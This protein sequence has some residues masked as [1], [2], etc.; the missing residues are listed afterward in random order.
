[1]ALIVC[2][3]CGKSFSDKA[4]QCPECGCPTEYSKSNITSENVS[5]RTKI[6][7]ENC[8]QS[9]NKKSLDDIIARSKM[10]NNNVEDRRQTFMI[11]DWNFSYGDSEK[12]FSFLYNTFHD[13]IDEILENYEKTF[14]LEVRAVSMVDIMMLEKALKE[15]DKSHGEVD[16]APFANR[17]IYK[18][19]DYRYEKNI[20]ERPADGVK[21]ELEE[22]FTNA[23]QKI[24]KTLHQEQTIAP[25]ID[26][27]NQFLLLY[28][29][30]DYENLCENTSIVDM[31]G[32][33]QFQYKKMKLI[34]LIQDKYQLDGYYGAEDPFEKYI[35]FFSD[36]SDDVVKRA[37]DEMKWRKKYLENLD[38]Y[39]L[40]EELAVDVERIILFLIQSMDEKCQFGINPYYY[41]WSSYKDIKTKLSL[42]NT[43]GNE[44]EKKSVLKECFLKF[45]FNIDV[46][47]CLLDVYGDQ[48]GEMSRLLTEFNVNVDA[49]KKA[50]FER[51]VDRIYAKINWKNVDSIMEA[52]K[53]VNDKRE[54][55]LYKGKMSDQYNKIYSEYTEYTRWKELL[56][57]KAALGL[58]EICDLFESKAGISNDAASE[59]LKK[60]LNIS[61]DVFIYF[62]HDDSVFKNG[63]NGFAITNQGFFVREMFK[64]PVFYS[65]DSL[66]SAE[67]TYTV[68]SGN[69][70]VDD[71]TLF[72]ITGDRVISNKL[73]IAAKYVIPLIAPCDKT[74]DKQKV[75]CVFCGR[76]IDIS[77]KFCQF[78]GEKNTSG[79]N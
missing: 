12:L 38:K 53:E 11:G 71:K 39:K 28:L 64:K 70:L 35:D 5:V 49:L 77:S 30:D 10:Y 2:V 56:E 16:P 76:K 57:E 14:S 31:D 17:F 32:Y 48:N 47:P 45:P 42:I 41:N 4:R 66:I 60:G 43:I 29:N 18:I 74:E 79:M 62:A 22:A 20:E 54:F 63:K 26:V 36:S 65:N 37:K 24:V 68:A 58:Q 50:L 55:L 72:Y 59:K 61:N 34:R 78:C 33:V 15:C 40:W 6:N 19:K 46:Y 1:M 23:A 73:Y 44:D 25:S 52:Y 13:E 69:V 27:Y 9:K 8:R 21:Y 3:E 67:H 75:F 7:G 51:Y